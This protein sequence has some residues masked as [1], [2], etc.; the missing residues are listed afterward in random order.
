MKA[1]PDGVVR[2]P[3]HDDVHDGVHY[4]VTGTGPDTVV[5]VHGFSD[6]LMT[7]RRIVPALAVNN[8]VIAIDL[9]S[10]G[11]STRPWRAPLLDTFA[12]TVADVLR[13]CDVDGPVTLIGNS[14]GGAV[15]AVFAQQH[16]E[17]VEA[18]VLIGMPG[19][20]G[21]PRSW[22]IAASRPAAW[23]LR[24]VTAPVPVPVLRGVVAW[25]YTHAAVPHAGSIDPATLTSY[26]DSYPDRDRLFALHPL[27]RALMRDLRR[28]HLERLLGEL[29]V[30]V[31]QLW[32][33]FDPLVPA[34]HAPRDRDRA[35]VLPGC[36]HCPQLDAPDAV[37]QAVL[38][39]L[40]EVRAAA[41]PDT[42][43]TFKT[44]RNLR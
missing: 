17:R 40:A 28:V 35:L 16:S 7:W 44:A 13:A 42:P 26:R 6:N 4:Q 22:R 31:L 12:D 3:V 23:T 19:V 38:P 43:H 5:L 11:L 18:A 37:L 25:A 8:R 24:R 21:V 2:G 27:A 1:V 39:F 32:G 41:V 9:P 10:H 30:P 15:C 14:M 20:H 34:R 33:R 36:G 29:P